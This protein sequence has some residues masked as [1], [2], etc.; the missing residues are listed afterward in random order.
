MKTIRAVER[1]IDLLLTISQEKSLREVAEISRQ[2]GLSRA[3]VYRVIHTLELKGLVRSFGE[4]LKVE[5]GPAAS[6]I[7]RAWDSQTPVL[8]P[9]NQFVDE[10]ARETRETAALMVPTGDGFTMCMYEVRG[11]HA[12]SFSRGVGHIQDSHRAASSKAIL[13]FLPAP[14]ASLA[15][16]AKERKTYG[17]ELE[18]TRTKGFA[19]SVS[20]LIPGAAS[21]AAPV[22]GGGGAVLASIC[23]FGAAARFRDATLA[24]YIRMLLDAAQRCSAAMGAQSGHATTAAMLK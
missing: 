22:F 12:L 1:A 9:C 20:E 19:L 10:L 4:P 14:P 7:A 15:V 21:L 13:A 6:T 5:L 24:G 8:A 11:S 23:L 2:L 17:R 18:E 3:T 16:P